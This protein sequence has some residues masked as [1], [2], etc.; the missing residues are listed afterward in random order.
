MNKSRIIGIA[1]LLLIV[2][3]FGFKYYQHAHPEK[4]VTETTAD[5]TSVSSEKSSDDSTVSPSKKEVNVKVETPINGTLKG[6]IEVGASG[7]NSFVVNIDKDKNWELVS[8]EFGESLAYEGF[9]TTD[10]VKSGLKKYLASM[11][12]RGV[13]GRNAHFVMSSGALKNPKTKLIASAIE[14]MGYVVN[15]VTAEQEGKYALKALLPKAYW[16]NSF[17]VDMGSGNTKV[18]WYEGSKL[19]SLEGPGAKYYQIP[20]NDQ[21]AYAKVKDLVNQ[22][23]AAKKEH[24]F[25]I[26]GVPFQLAKQVRQGDQ[27]FTALEDPDFYSA[28]DDVKVKSGL[29]LY[30]AI[31]DGSEAKDVIFDW[32]ANFT[33]GFLMTLN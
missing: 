20:M 19:K 24:V 13:S 30:R 16:E 1:V 14:S 18:S 7:F 29:N 32:D 31:T 5:S 21:D 11:F 9:A 10:D 17:V 4:F 3:I 2:A 15:R 25:I 33:I 28:G 26:G 27:R 22:V 12:T 8:K 6:V 23:P